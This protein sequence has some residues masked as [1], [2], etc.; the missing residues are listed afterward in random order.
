[1]NSSEMLRKYPG[2]AVVAATEVVAT[3]IVT[4]A[5]LE[6]HPMPVHELLGFYSFMTFYVG[7]P[8]GIVTQ[9][10][11]HIVDFL[12]GK[13]PQFP[14]SPEFPQTPGVK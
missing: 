1:M 12:K 10:V 11:L 8:A 4:T 7:V 14:Q 2:A 3:G 6:G 13:R 9:G 5:A